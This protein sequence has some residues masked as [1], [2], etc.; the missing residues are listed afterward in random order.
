MLYCCVTID[1]LSQ[2][3]RS[4]VTEAGAFVEEIRT[5]AAM[6]GATVGTRKVPLIL[7]F[8]SGGM[9]DGIQAAEALNRLVNAFIKYEPFLRGGSLVVHETSSSEDALACA[10]SIRYQ[11]FAAYSYVFSPQASKVMAKYYD[12]HIDT[13]TPPFHASS[14]GTADASLLFDRPLLAA[15]LARALAKSERRG[16][17]LVHLEAGRGARSMEALLKAVG[18]PENRALVLDGSKTRPLPFSPLVE[19]VAA[20]QASSN[21][22]PSVL[23]HESTAFD[24]VAASSFSEGVPESVSKGCTAF[25]DAWLDRFGS[26]GGLVACDDPSSFSE[27]VQ[28]LIASR[29]SEGRGSE[30]YVSISDEGLNNSWSGAWAAR[31]PAGLANSDDRVVAAQKALGSTTGRV[32][33]ALAHRFRSIAGS[34]SDAKNHE[35]IQDLLQ[36]LPQ[37][38]SLYLYI[39]AIIENELSASELSIFVGSLGLRP[40][41]EI[42]LRK[43]LS[44]AGLVEPLSSRTPI[45]PMDQ[46]YIARVIGAEA[47]EA[48]QTHFSRYL[49]G[50]YRAGRIRPSIGFLHRVGEQP[51]EERLLYDCMFEEVMRPDSP[52]LGEPTFLSASS[53]CIYRFWSALQTRDRLACEAT[54]LAA[55]DRITGSRAQTMRALVHAELAYALGDPERASKGAREAMLA[56]GK[57]APPRLEARSQRMMGLSALALARPAEAADYLTNAQELSESSGD[58]Y[59]RMMAAYTK[60]IVEFLS[61][62]LVRSLKALNCAEESA[63]RLFRMDIR[64]A[65]EALRGRIDLELGSYDEAKRRFASLNELADTYSISG[66]GQRAV[67]W[68]A[69]ALAYAG[70]FDDAVSLLEAESND[71]EARVFRGE[72]EI[73]R[74]KPQS[75][76]I[77]LT[78]PEN[79]PIRS[80]DPPDSISW[81]SLFSEFEGRGIGFDASNS[82]LAVC[83]TALALFAQGL[84]EHNPACAVDLHTLTRSDR[85]SRNDPGM[86]TYS[87]LCYL[88]EEQLQDPPVDKQTVLSRSFKILQQRAGRIE[89]RAQRALYMEKNA[90]NKRLIEA[91]RIHKFI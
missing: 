23:E 86:G 74:G 59:E 1:Y 22:M 18:L 33:E 75:A 12:A 68:Q 72:L 42:V 34:G 55:D 37:E 73:L 90:W 58:E 40:Q 32:N 57:G 49:I 88:L 77:W 46:A 24:F 85:D 10:S 79:P 76:R 20:Y 21:A 67:I 27:E 65:I 84:D 54:A 8:P 25:L 81:D 3:E 19:V 61:G 2:L 78:T 5:I 16:P 69:R 82:P 80:F 39:L 83:R 6:F 51:A 17:R 50:L 53:A 13:W 26:Q 89:N 45:Q 71:A 66:A 64:A 31:V 9:F 87:F 70:E 28:E 52:R 43:L 38:A 14:L 36:I 91:A 11:N 7:S 35:V 47:A 63:A 60:A 62:A 48:I 56:L 15:T 30:R 44:R 4:G 29:L 41:G